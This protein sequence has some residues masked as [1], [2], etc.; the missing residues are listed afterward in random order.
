[1]VGKSQKR[2]RLQFWK[3]FEKRFGRIKIFAYIGSIKKSTHMKFGRIIEGFSF[4]PTCSLNWYTYENKKHYFLTVGWLFW[5]AT[6]LR[7]FAW[8]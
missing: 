8:R 3:V 7:K 4:L 6:T 2:K 5:Y 1:M